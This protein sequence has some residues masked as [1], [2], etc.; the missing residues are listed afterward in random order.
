[1]SHTGES[2]EDENRQKGATHKSTPHRGGGACTLVKKKKKK[3]INMT[4]MALADRNRAMLY[5]T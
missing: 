2:D 3:E 4:N 5:E 1:M